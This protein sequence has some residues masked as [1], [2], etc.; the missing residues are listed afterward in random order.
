MPQRDA[1]AGDLRRGRTGAKATVFRQADLAETLAWIGRGATPFYDG[2]IGQRLVGLNNDTGGHPGADAW[3]ITGDR[4]LPLYLV[5]G[6]GASRP[7][8]PVVGWN[9]DQLRTEACST[10]RNCRRR[11]S[12]NIRAYPGMSLPPMSPATTACCNATKDTSS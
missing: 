5:T 4:T 8:L 3:R 7:T 11:R 12:S 10:A 6:D 2:E 9:P 1:G